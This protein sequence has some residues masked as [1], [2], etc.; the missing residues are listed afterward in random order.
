MR[1]TIRAAAEGRS[2]AMYSAR[3]SSER[4]DRRVHLTRIRPSREDR[5]DLFIAREVSRIR[6]AE[7][8]FNLPDLPLL[9]FDAFHFQR[10]LDDYP[11]GRF[12]HGSSSAGC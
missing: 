3:A 5:R 7:P 1:S 4:M 8:F 9:K 6:L 11:G 2:C 10:Q 12:T